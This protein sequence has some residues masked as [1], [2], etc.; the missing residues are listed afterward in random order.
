MNSP[1]AQDN[2]GHSF[3]QLFETRA[4]ARPVGFDSAPPPAGGPLRP[5]T[6]LD[7]APPPQ[8]GSSHSLAPAV[9]PFLETMQSPLAD[10]EEAAALP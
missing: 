3:Q 4:T 1:Y 5:F 6:A 10:A 8:P 9:S 2:R 7:I